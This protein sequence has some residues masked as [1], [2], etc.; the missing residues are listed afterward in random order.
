MRIRN[1]L[2]RGTLIFAGIYLRRFMN[3][4]ARPVAVRHTQRFLPKDKN[5]RWDFPIGTHRVCADLMQ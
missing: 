4:K 1:V 2:S 5:R 3:E